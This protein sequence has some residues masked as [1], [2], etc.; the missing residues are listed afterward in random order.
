MLIAQSCPTP[1]DPMD[2]S[3]PGSSVHV[4]LQPRILEWVA[5]PFSRGSSWPWDWTWVS[6]V[7]QADSLP[8]EP[9]GKANSC[10]M[11]SKFKFSF[12]DLFAIFSQIFSICGCLTWRANGIAVRRK[13]SIKYNND[14]SF[15]FAPQQNVSVYLNKDQDVFKRII[16]FNSC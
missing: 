7:L 15:H 3:P 4:I 12:L 13:G 2:Y 5:I 10:L 11:H 9:P 6:F 14:S 1:C 8:P 16:T